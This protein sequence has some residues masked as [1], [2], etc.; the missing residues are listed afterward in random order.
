MHASTTTDRG[1]GGGG[2]SWRLPPDETLQVQDPK[3]KEEDLAYT[4]EGHNWRSIIF[5]LLVIG[6]VI[7]GI[8]TAIYLLGYVDELLY[9]SGRRMILDE[10]IQGDLAPNR[11][12]PT[13]VTRSKFV[14]QSD[15]GGLAVLDTANDS[16][17][18]LVTNHT[19]RQLNVKGYQCTSDLRYVLFK[20]N[21]KQVFRSSFTAFYTVYDVTNDHHMPV[22]LKDS[23]KVQRTR[24]QFATWLGNT[25]ALVIVADNDIYLR[26]SPSDEED[27]RLTNTGQTDTIYNGV[28]DWLYQ[29]EIFSSP[30]AI[31]GSSDGTHI[32]YM[33]FNDSNVN[34]M[35]YPWF[36]A[37][38]IIASSGVTSGGIF[39]ETRTI[40]YPTPGTQNPE[41]QLW[42]LD[43]TN[44]TEIQRNRVKPPAALEGQEYY[45]TSADWVAPNHQVSVVWI[46]RAQNLSIV[47]VCIAPNW[48]C[49]ETHSENAPENEWLDILPHPVFSLDGDSFLMLAGI[50]ETG[51]EHFTHIKHVTITQQRLSV[52]SHGRYE[53]V[54]VITHGKHHHQV[55]RI[56]AWDMVNHLV[57]YLGTQ[58]KKPGQK[59]LYVVK[60]PV[61]E[62]VR[63]SEPHC[64]TCDL[65][66][67]LWSSRYYYS[68]CTH[69]EVHMS[70]T[71]SISSDVGIEYY[72]LECLGPGLPLSGVHSAETHRLVRI[73]YD[74]R[75]YHT[76]RLQQLALPTSRSY[77]IPLLHGTRAQV[78]ILLPPSWR[79]ELR[80]A[81]FPVLV[82]VNGRPGSLTVSDKFRIDW[83]TYMSSRNDVVYIRLDV[84]GS[85]GQSKSALFRRLGGVEVQDQLSVL[86][87]LLGTLKFLDETRVGVWGWGYGGYVTSMLMGSQQNVFKCGIAVSP[88]TDWLYYNSA[89]TEKIL[90]PPAENYK[91]Y[92]EA[93]ATQRARHIPSYSFFLLHGLADNTAPYLHGVQLA[94]ALTE[95]GVL[96]RYQSYADEGHELTGVAEHVYRSMEEYLRDCLILDPDD[97][98]PKKTNE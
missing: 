27:I 81:A 29:E 6:F 82:E 92:V 1:G 43:V 74:T 60:D 78:Q 34:A 83:G 24:L 61:N 95:A 19:L 64:I 49:I 85:K 42:I 89:F 54:A 50:Q 86:K 21:V 93:D 79:E 16:V 88:I 26:Q 62:D 4:Q 67:V 18:T 94:R 25:T 35:S 69:F 58:D 33:S 53:Q 30:E 56:L 3:S 47:S 65:G 46:T 51:T 11:L 80:D 66:E 32:M 7:T 98:K 48:T 97:S 75:P 12:T 44:I 72:I 9:W 36:S 77:E 76:E 55:L 39:P 40:R 22:T 52:I 23:P 8:I 90:G 59:H 84:R 28:P 38:P 73:L 37:G 15:D 68:N 96:F 63:R 20:H 2:G 41:I 14:F 70:P 91:N 87:Y 45:L 71:T 57:Y 31:W 10:Y 5:S 17:T 13:W